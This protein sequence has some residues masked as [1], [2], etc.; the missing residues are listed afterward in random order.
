MKINFHLDELERMKKENAYLKKL[1]TNMMHQREAK[2]GTEEKIDVA[3]IQSIK[4]KGELK[5]FITQ[6]GQV[7]VDECHH[8]SAYTFEKV[9]KAIR[10]KFVYGLTATPIR[11]D[12]LHPIIFMQC[13][14]VRYKV[15]GKRQA[16]IRPFKHQLIPKYTRFKSGSSD[17]QELI[18]K[19]RLTKI[20][21]SNYLMMSS[22]NSKQGDLQLS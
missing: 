16:K 20:E 22:T 3:T 18:E 13:G 8:I 14:P 1:L 6:Y 5:S 4:S 7:I 15:D 12:G 21:I 9:L 17:L 19:S 11:K 10:A 2:A